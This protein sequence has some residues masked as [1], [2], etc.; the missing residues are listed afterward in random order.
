MSFMLS[1]YHF[2]GIKI[3][4]KYKQALIKSIYDQYNFL[5]EH[6]NNSCVGQKQVLFLC[7]AYLQLIQKKN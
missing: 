1:N 7:S 6:K 5:I 2:I 3:Y 4:K